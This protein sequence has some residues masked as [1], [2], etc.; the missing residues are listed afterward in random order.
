M[1]T[2]KMIYLVG[3]GRSGSTAV[4]DLVGSHRDVFVAGEINYLAESSAL[5]WK[6]TC[7]KAIDDCAIW[8]GSIP[9][10]TRRFE[11]PWGF[12]SMLSRRNRVAY[13]AAWSG[14]LDSLRERTRRQIILDC[15]KT[16][17]R[18]ALRP[19]ALRLVVRQHIRVLWVVRP[20][21][22]TLRSVAAVPSNWREEAQGHNG[23]LPTMTMGARLAKNKRLLMLSTAAA[24]VIANLVA[25][26]YFATFG[27]YRVSWIDLQDSPKEMSAKAIAGLG[28]PLSTDAPP[29]RCRHFVGGN[30]A[31]W[32]TE[33]S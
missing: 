28:L 15:S 11:S 5:G 16:S 19:L 33:E 31:R 4:S 29:P 6:C 17:L 25:A 12:V 30:R 20:L 21:R 2:D 3:Y 10:S 1:G 18:V 32:T 26:I 24:W 8:H 22:S 14:S 23:A 13:R 7:G 9:P 27:G